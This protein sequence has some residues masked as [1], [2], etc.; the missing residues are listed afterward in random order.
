M[1]LPG[2]PAPK[3]ATCEPVSHGPCPTGGSAH[4]MFSLGSVTQPWISCRW[5]SRSR[6]ASHFASCE[7]STYSS[8]L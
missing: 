8:A 3:R 5:T 1:H 6:N 2:S 4:Q 7:R